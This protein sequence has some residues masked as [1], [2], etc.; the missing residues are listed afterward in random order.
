[1]TT[2]QAPLVEAELKTVENMESLLEAAFSGNDISTLVDSQTKL[3][4]DLG[5]NS[6]GL[7]NYLNALFTFVPLFSE[8]P[9]EEDAQRIINKNEELGAAFGA[10]LTSQPGYEMLSNTEFSSIPENE[11]FINRT[12][13]FFTDG[14]QIVQDPRYG[15]QYFKNE[16]LPSV[17]ASYFVSFA[18]TFK[19]A[20]EFTPII[21]P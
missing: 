1:V 8:N 15:Y 11:L 9:S 4:E 21:S 18:E 14:F 3:F 2:T 5:G 10:L 12:L 13:N 7:P 19:R 6:S 17:F 20:V 16:T